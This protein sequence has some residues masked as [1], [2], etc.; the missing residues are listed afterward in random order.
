M[1]VFSF[2]SKLVNQIVVSPVDITPINV[3]IKRYFIDIK[4]RI[5]QLTNIIDRMGKRERINTD[6]IKWR[7]LISAV[8]FKNGNLMHTHVNSNTT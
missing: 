5:Q 2:L 1:N 3:K 4:C 7:M 6:L 8:I